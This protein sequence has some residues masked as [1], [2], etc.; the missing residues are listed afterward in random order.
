MIAVSI[1]LGNPPAWVEAELKARKTAELVGS[2]GA[3]SV[4]LRGRAEQ[5]DAILVAHNVLPC[6]SCCPCV[7]I[8]AGVLTSVSSSKYENFINSE[9][10]KKF[11]HLPIY[12]QT[13]ETL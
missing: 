2:A 8:W 11:R 7:V 4:L 6:K 5:A 1:I 12:P 13:S 10:C 9:I 3:N